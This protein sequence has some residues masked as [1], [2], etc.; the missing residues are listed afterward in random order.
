MTIAT[1]GDLKTAVPNWLRRADLAGMVPDFIMIAEREM[2]R[3]LRT[4][5]QLGRQAITIDGE[6]VAAPASFR[7]VRSLRLTSGPGR[8]LREVTPEQMARQKAGT[9]GLAG[10]PQ[11]FTVIGPQIEVWPVPDAA[12]EATAE[13]QAGIAPL[14]DDNPTNWILA[15]HPDAYLFGALAAGAAY[16]KSDD[17]ASAWQAQFERV[18]GDIQEAVRTSYDRTLRADP[19]LGPAGRAFNA[20]TGDF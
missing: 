19:G 10:A 6:F 7:M 20:I 3:V 16:T 2:D 13:L 12:Y 18:L 1:Y 9:P 15:G 5:L 17:R 8:A 14:S 4:A 11:W